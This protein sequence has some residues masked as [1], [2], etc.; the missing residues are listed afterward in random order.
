[1]R[2]TALIARLMPAIVLASAAACR[3]PVPPPASSAPT[4]ASVGPANPGDSAND[5]SAPYEGPAVSLTLNGKDSPTRATVRVTFPTGGW[6]LTPDRS[7]VKDHFG[8]AHLTFSG[9]AP[10]DMVAQVLEDKEWAWESA[11]PF[12]RGEVWVRIVRR[13]Q[14]ASSEYRRAAKAP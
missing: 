3:A 4:P 1:M 5:S 6:E 8:V 12:S 7:R 2:L 11:E 9:P 10:D 14:P 13:G